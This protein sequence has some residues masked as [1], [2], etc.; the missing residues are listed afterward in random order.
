MHLQQRVHLQ[1][2]SLLKSSR[3]IRANRLSLKAVENQDY[4]ESHKDQHAALNAADADEV[5]V[6]M[7]TQ[8][9]ATTECQSTCE[10]AGNAHHA[11]ELDRNQNAVTTARPLARSAP[12]GAGRARVFTGM[13]TA[14]WSTALRVQDRH[15]AM[16]D[17]LQKSDFADNLIVLGSLSPPTMS[18]P[19]N[20]SS[21][22]HSDDV[23]HY[24]F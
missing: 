23:N 10:A 4:A 15:A 7:W 2:R 1:S 19:S 3:P 14:M 11:F 5:A 13:L 9:H 18:D 16:L 8:L 17:A 24:D 6:L 20:I 21:P 22:Q 12:H